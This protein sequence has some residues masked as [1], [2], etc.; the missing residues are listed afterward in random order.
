MSYEQQNLRRSTIMRQLRN[1]ART[2]ADPNLGRAWIGW[3]L[4]NL[5][6]DRKAALSRDAFEDAL[7]AAYWAHGL[8]ELV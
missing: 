6:E 1:H 7:D 2:F 5:A 8:R 4:Q 3:E